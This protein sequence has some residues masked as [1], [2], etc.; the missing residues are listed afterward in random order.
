MW[1][2]FNPMKTKRILAFL[3]LVLFLNSC[4]VRSLATLTS[5]NLVEKP[6]EEVVI[7]YEDTY[8]LMIIPVVIEGKTY[9]F[10]YD[11]G[12]GS[13]VISREISEL[14]SF[15]NKGGIKV[16]DAF[17]STSEL[18][19]G[20]VTEI[21]INSLKYTKVGAIVMDFNE[22]E[23]FRCLRI[24]GILGMNVLKLHNWKVDYDKMEIVAYDIDQEMT[25]P[26]NSYTFSFVTK[27]GTP[28]IELSV[29]NQREKF[30]VDTGKNSELISVSPG[31]K[32]DGK[33]QMSVGQSSF[34]MF[35]KTEVDTTYFI[36]ADFSDTNGFDIANVSV[37]QTNNN[38][39]NMGNGFLK[40]NYHYV[41]FDFKNRRM[42]CCQPK[43]AENAYYTYGISV[44]MLNGN[45]V[46]GSKDLN[47]SD[48]TKQVYMQDTIVEAN[49][50]RITNENICDIVDSFSAYKR[51][52]R[53]V[54]L[55]IKH[56]SQETEMTFPCEEVH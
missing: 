20:T 9:R 44:I 28:F 33:K 41:L 35:G 52:K 42:H 32:L 21:S 29:D 48:Q 10:I 18:P 36:K 46:I 12:A 22:N 17:E 49:G 55:K 2:I 50:V 3:L 34:G 38:K 24:D 1:I 11:T 51:E 31:I 27:V 39:S 23:Q 40:K 56:N 13:T 37:T 14:K 15:K 53:P 26:E 54:V 30:M 43:S 47:F 5:S 8:G 16:N 6:K 4:V 7:K 25:A 45:M 19:V